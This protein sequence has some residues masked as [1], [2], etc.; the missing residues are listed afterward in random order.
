MLTQEN[1]INKLREV[2][3]ILKKEYGVAKIGIFGSYS[4]QEQSSKSDV[5]IFIE[6]KKP[7]GLAFMDLANYLEKILR[8]KVD[9]LTPEGIKSIRVHEIAQYIKE[10]LVYI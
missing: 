5:D 4:R 3:P 9:I 2:L 6:F 8:R 7:I 1:V 10:N